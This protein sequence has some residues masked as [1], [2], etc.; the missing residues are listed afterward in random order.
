MTVKGNTV[1][2]T[3]QDISGMS[4]YKVSELKSALEFAGYEMVVE[5]KD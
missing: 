2:L 4:H 3:S 5:T 1:V